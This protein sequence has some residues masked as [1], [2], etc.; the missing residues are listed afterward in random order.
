MQ[1]L[2]DSELYVWLYWSDRGQ[3]IAEEIT[4]LLGFQPHEKSVYQG[5]CDL[6]WETKNFGSSVKLAESLKSYIDTPEIVLIKATGKV[7][8]EREV[9]IL[10]DS[11]AKN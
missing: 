11:R 6:R 2:S 1:S 7:S 4:D 3:K 5:I 9:L 10:K 8:G